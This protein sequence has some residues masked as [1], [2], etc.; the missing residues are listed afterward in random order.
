[1]LGTLCTAAGGVVVPNR[2]LT[3]TIIV[4]LPFFFALKVHV[5]C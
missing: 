4:L 3:G 2:L 1:M 5:A